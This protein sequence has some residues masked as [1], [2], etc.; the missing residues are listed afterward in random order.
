VFSYDQDIIQP[1]DVEIV[2]CT[3]ITP[4]VPDP[5]V[6]DVAKDNGKQQIFNAAGVTDLFNLTNIRSECTYEFLLY[7]TAEAIMTDSSL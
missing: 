2:D 7:E 5:D 4:V 6:L 3:L 1:F